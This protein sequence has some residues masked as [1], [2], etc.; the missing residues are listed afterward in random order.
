MMSKKGKKQIF[1]LLIFTLT[2]LIFYKSLLT[3]HNVKLLLETELIQSDLNLGH[4]P[5]FPTYGQWSSYVIS[6][7]KEF[8]IPVFVENI[9]SD[10]YIFLDE[11]VGGG[12]FSTQGRNGQLFSL[13]V[14]E[15]IPVSDT[16]LSYTAPVI[17]GDFYRAHYLQIETSRW[18]QRIRNTRE[19]NVYFI[20]NIRIKVMNQDGTC[21]N[22][23]GVES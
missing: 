12:T 5:D 7:E 19:I 17:F 14:F 21:N 3:S 20:N 11:G 9:G 10:V 23:C 8:L 4:H 2:M 18:T 13:L 15:S 1:Y 16:I 22:Y 6:V